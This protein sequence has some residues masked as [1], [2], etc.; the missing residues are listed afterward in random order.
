MRNEPR[1]SEPSSP[2]HRRVAML[3]LAAALVAGCSGGGSGDSSGTASDTVGGGGGNAGSVP[4]TARDWPR[5]ALDSRFKSDRPD[6]DILFGRSLSLSADGRVL[7]VGS[8]TSDQFPVGQ[9]EVFERDAQSGWQ[10][11]APVPDPSGGRG[12]GLGS[13]QQL[14]RGGQRVVLGADSW[15]GPY[16][17]LGDG[18]DSNSV[19]GAVQVFDRQPDGAWQAIALLTHPN[20]QPLDY[21][22][23]SVAASAD[24]QL[25]VA[26]AP[27]RDFGDASINGSPIDSRQRSGAAYVYAHNGSEF[28]LIQQ[29]RHPNPDAEDHFGERLVLSADGSTLVVA[30]HGDD[31]NALGVN[32]VAILQDNS[33]ED[34][35]AA[36][37]YSRQADGRFALDAVLKSP[38]NTHLDTFAYGL[39]LSAD[40]NTLAVEAEGISAGLFELWYD[41]PPAD[42]TPGGEAI[43]YRR[44]TNGWR[45]TQRIPAPSASL[46]A[47]R[48]GVCMTLSANG[49][50]LAV[51]MPGFTGVPGDGGLNDG[52]VFTYVRNDAG[53]YRPFKSARLPEGLSG[54]ESLGC[55]LAISADNRWLAAGSADETSG[56]G[57]INPALGAEPRNSGSGAVYLFDLSR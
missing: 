33:D 14:V 25:I 45:F 56:G 1:T 28:E 46:G 27:G 24:G 43:I 53:G 41:R 38:S 6:R 26:G 48:F 9:F 54:G 42:L 5:A 40:G 30:A 37:V 17:R 52:A 50:F 18:G 20:P 22:G 29:L 57:G 35:G 3:A 4:A 49:D 16:T 34:S 31:S 15:F 8:S 21:L 55:G 36:M 13:S 23:R 39:A 10:I 51:G 12:S 11:V 44:D 47:D 19:L 32:G 7:L 2:I